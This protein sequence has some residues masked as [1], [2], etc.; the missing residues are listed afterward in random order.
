MRD[1]QYALR[2]LRRR[3][4]FAL[5]AV[6]T[7]ALGIGA[8]TAIFSVVNALLFRPLPVEAAAAL[9]SVQVS[10][11]GFTLGGEEVPI[12]ISYPDYRDYRELEVFEDAIAFNSSVVQL[13][14]GESA[15]ER[16]FMMVVSPNYFSMLGVEAPLGRTFTPEE[17][18]TAADANLVVLSSAF[19]RSR[20]AGDPDI[21]GQT[22]LLNGSAF[23]VVGVTPE[24]FPG[25]GGPLILDGYVPITAWD[26]LQPQRRGA[27]EERGDPGYR[28]IARLR[29]GASLGEARA[30]ADVR[31]A[32][33]ASEYPDT[34]AGTHVWVHPEPTTRLEP[35]ASVYLPPVA[36]VFMTLVSLVLL[37]A[38]ANVANLLLA[39]A[40]GRQKEI[41]IRAALGSGRARIVRQMLT[42]SLL[43]SL[44][45]AAGGLLL[46]H[47][48]T[49]VLSSVRIASDLPIAFD[50]GL[51]Y[52]VFYFALAVSLLTSI[53]S[54]LVPSLHAARTNLHE[55]LKV[56]GRTS[57]SAG[58]QRLRGLL[59]VSQVAVSLLLLISA[60]LFVRSMQNFSAMDLGFRTEN[61][62][63]LTV[64]AGLR[65]L[66]E[67]EGRLFFRTLL[68]RVRALPGVRSASLGTTV[69]IG[70]GQDGTRLYAEGRVASREEQQISVFCS[71]VA[72]DY[73]DTMGVP[74]V[75]GRPITRDDT[76]ASRGVVVVN[77]VL[78]EQLWPGLDPLTQRLSVESQDGPFLDVVGVAKVHVYNLPGEDPWPFLYLPLAQSYRSLRTVHVHTEANP[79]ALAAT[80]R[81]EIQA[82][83]PDM[84]VFDVRSMENHLREG[85][86]ALMLKL[87]SG[88]AGAFGL[89]GLVLA[90]IGLYGVMAY[91]VTQRVHE[92]G[93]RMALGA[94]SGDI[95][96]MVLRHAGALTASGVALGLGAAFLLT[97]SLANLLVG[98]GPTDPLT[99]AGF[100]AIL[101]LVAV[102]S[103]WLPAWRATRVDPM[104]A[105]Y[106][107]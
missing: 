41:A 24:S 13:R 69:P 25:T 99:Y 9:V 17:L 10:Q 86:A 27:Y 15:A 66:R 73:F 26:V 5:V 22:V 87:G 3:P 50:V 97:R 74:I 53:A 62:L 4:G 100:S 33:L 46:A 75:A 70:M 93:V 39:R 84:P 42:E 107:E 11:P 35:S 56:G 60:G 105:L 6:A 21:V 30:A 88:L 80:I 8:T 32:H 1:L 90:C 77:E 47:W 104:V 85:K 64:D 44:A 92:M 94:S 101:V 98:V 16:A 36:T 76:E 68:D 72:S 45:G 7:L 14:A 19:W 81:G 79:T 51:N 31:A 12:G 18:E 89:I 55:A 23:R 102:L 59:V 2:T 95:L 67:Q 40:A 49:R 37:I 38:C 82:L 57:G 83:D 34:N 103:A 106:D 61:H 43:L 78:A 20:F 29:Q 52:Q 58:R 48:A 71:R 91:W 96:S 28:M 63:M 54:G 65:G